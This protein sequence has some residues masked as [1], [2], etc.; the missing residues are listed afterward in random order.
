MKAVWYTSVALAALLLV[1]ASRLISQDAALVSGAL[2]ALK[3]ESQPGKPNLVGAPPKFKVTKQTIAYLDK[4]MKDGRS[5]EV[6]N[7][8]A[9]KILDV[10]N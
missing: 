10:K 2:G 1:G 5:I 9:I 3:F 6:Q 8:G 4:L 7:N